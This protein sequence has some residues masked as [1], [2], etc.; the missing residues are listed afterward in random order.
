MLER[1]IPRIRVEE[2]DAG[3]FQIVCGVILDN[4]IAVELTTIEEGRHMIKITRKGR[5]VDGSPFR[6]DIEAS[7]VTKRQRANGKYYDLQ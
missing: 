6:V 2:Q 5:P 7:S 4:T 1:S 3:S